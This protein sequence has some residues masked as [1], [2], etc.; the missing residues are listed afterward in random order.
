MTAAQREPGVL[1]HALLWLCVLAPLFFATYNFATWAASERSEVI[2]LVFEWEREI[3]FWP[4]TIVPYWSIDLL[5]GMSFLLP[6]TRVALNRHAFRLLSVQLI[7]IG[8]FLLWPLKF[9]FSRPELDGVYGW[10]FDVL[11]SFDKPF[12]QAPS[13]HIAIL[14]VLW[15]CYARHLQNT[16]R[17]LMHCWFALIGLSVLTTY[18][19]HFI[20]VPTGALVGWLCV[21]LWPQRQPAMLYQL[22]P[23]SDPKRRQVALRYASAAFVLTLTALVKSGAGLWLLWPAVSL[24]MVAMN[25]AIFGVSGFQKNHLGSLSMATRW[26][27]GPYLAGAWINSRLWTHKTSQ[28][29]HVM[30]DVWL[31]RLPTAGELEHSRFTSVIDLCAELSIGS[32]SISYYS[33]PVLDLTPPSLERCLE[34]AEAI[35]NGRH[36]GPVL[37]CCALG[38]SRSA[39]A[40]AAW[41]LHTGRATDVESAIHAIQSAR[42]HV[43]L[44]QS[45]CLLLAGITNNAHTH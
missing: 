15:V 5:Y 26:L 10:M 38:Y 11:A 39:V 4:W 18:Q 17:W 43:V 37:V 3:P 40:I 7:A 28:A 35:E 8:C 34:A 19:H 12:N 44:H 1:K 32:D 16:W 13:L 41:L 22:Q 9:S 45:H 14:V 20:D 33:L 29:N 6:R 27:L 31:G 42:P 36:S 21:W 30:D 25:Y 24:L 2:S 23:T